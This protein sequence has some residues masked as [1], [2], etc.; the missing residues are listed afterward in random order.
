[1]PSVALNAWGSMTEIREFRPGAGQAS[2][3]PRPVL[4]AV[5]VPAMHL[6]YRW[7]VTGPHAHSVDSRTSI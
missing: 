3:R 7:A 2:A 6:T 4:P 5:A 1:M